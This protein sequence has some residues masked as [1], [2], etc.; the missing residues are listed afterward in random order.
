MTKKTLLA[1]VIVL[2]L[3]L[4]SSAQNVIQLPSLSIEGSR[5]DSKVTYDSQR[6]VYTYE[7]T[8][9]AAATNKAPIQGFSVDIRGRIARSQLDPDLRNN[10]TRTE[11]TT[12]GQI[13]PSTTIPV[14]V[15]MPDPAIENLSGPTMDGSVSF[16]YWS[17]RG[18]VLKPGERRGGFRLESKFPPAWREAVIGPS[19]AG[20]VPIL[21]TTRAPDVEYSPASDSKYEITTKVLAPYDLDE[22]ALFLGGG[23]SPRE[24]NV[25]LRYVTPTENRIQ[26]PAGT[27]S[28]DVTVVFGRT[29]N[30]ATF[31]A[32]LDGADITSQFRPMAGVVDTVPIPLGAGTTKLQLSIEGTTSSG[33]T[34]RD[35][36]TLTFIV[37]RM[38]G[39]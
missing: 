23:Q 5:I 39:Q 30:V 32:T 36:D 4:S 25:F 22:S 17:L 28:C 34:A 37:N 35:T 16:A 7:Y 15:L 38:S 20:W 19:S 33:R 6:G 21:Q 14:G 12:V 11:T 8:L 3:A 10:I 18:G 2:C 27:T 29:T 9:I 24:V 31:T 26:L 13:Q 1:T